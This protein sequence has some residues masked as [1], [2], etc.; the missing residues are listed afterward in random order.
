[1]PWRA[2]PSTLALTMKVVLTIAGSDPCGGAGLQGDLKTLAAFGVFGAAVPTLL[3]VQDTRG[4]RRVEV[5]DPDLVAQQLRAVL[6]DLPVA[7]VKTGALGNAAVVAA[8]A[9]ILAA[10]PHLPLVVDPVLGASAGRDLSGADAVAALRDQLLPR[11]LL[12]TPNL[13]EASR[14]LGRP[15]T[16]LAHMAA[17]A[18]DLA[19]LGPSAVLLKGGHLVGDEL[20]DL[21]HING[22]AIVLPGQRLHVGPTHGTGCALSAA[23][24]A[25]LAQGVGLEG[26]CQQGISW[27]RGAMAHGL[28]LGQGQRL[29]HHGWRA[30]RGS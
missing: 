15:I 2:A 14:L 4:V 19:A 18:A 16:E 20:V 8:V 27:L 28:S 22:E 6:D 26:A 11:T 5:L 17:A 24:T 3:T 9:E 23:I 12:L 30:G 10:W 1:M 25:L 21:L 13:P 7:A 29:L